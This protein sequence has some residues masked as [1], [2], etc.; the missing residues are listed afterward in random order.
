MFQV[1][2]KAVLPQSPVAPNRIKLMV[3]AFALS[4][5]IGLMAAL[6]V[7]LPRMTLIQDERD[8]EYYLGA[9]V[10][11]LIPETLTP[12]ESNRNRKLFLVRVLLVFLL[13]ISLV[14]ILI[15]LFK[16]FQIFQL[17]AK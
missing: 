13:A 5:G 4:I 8:I 16:K 15:V 17:F 12:S 2:D 3:L 14:P 9:P 6:V 11:G 10:V 1:V 7:E